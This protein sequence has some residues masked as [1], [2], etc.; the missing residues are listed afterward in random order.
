MPKKELSPVQA[1]ES[2]VV[3]PLKYWPRGGTLL[4]QFGRHKTHHLQG[5]SLVRGETQPAQ[6]DINVT[7]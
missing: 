4:A 2:T 5:G 7:N 3:T 1:R 6:N